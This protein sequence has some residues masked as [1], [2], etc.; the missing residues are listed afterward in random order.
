MKQPLRIGH[1]GAAG[2]A[3]ENTLLSVETA[4]SF[5]VDVVEI[6][7]HAPAAL[8]AAL[9]TRRDAPLFVLLNTVKGR[10]VSFME[11]RMEWHYLPLDKDHYN[12]AL[13]EL[14]TP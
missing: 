9:A 6:D 12:Q 11:G 4:L 2:Y 10:G 8:D 14:A 3:P 1:R 13:L 7:G 5:G